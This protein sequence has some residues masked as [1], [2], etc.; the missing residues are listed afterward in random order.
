MAKYAV[1]PKPDFAALSL[2]EQLEAY[3]ELSVTQRKSKFPSKEQGIAALN[4][5]WKR[6]LK[7]NPISEDEKAAAKEKA[8][9]E[10]KAAREDEKAAKPAKAPK[11]KKE[12][13][14]G[15]TRTR[16]NLEDKIV[17]LT[18]K[19]ANPRREGTAAYDH[20][21]VML[22]SKTVGDYLAAFKEDDRRTAS[23]WLWNTVRDGWVE[24]EP[25]G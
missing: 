21:E 9:A 4:S 7:D 19:K 8:A 20:F 15:G 16:R 13:A 18:E 6:W 17:I 11:A 23:Q 25:A 14:E 3:N 5:E 22:T 2:A 24:L 1:Y 12:K 10:K